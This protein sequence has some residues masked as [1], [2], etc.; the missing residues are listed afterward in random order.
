MPRS[1]WTIEL[2]SISLNAKG[3]LWYILWFTASRKHKQLAR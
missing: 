1:T 3:T 2:Q